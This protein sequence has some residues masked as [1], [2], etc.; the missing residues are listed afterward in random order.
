MIIIAEP[1]HGHGCAG[2]SIVAIAA[3]SSACCCCFFVGCTGKTAIAK[4]RT[5]RPFKI[6]D[7]AD[8]E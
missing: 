7:W 5:K 8:E 3:L 6:P 2:F 4:L 1:Q